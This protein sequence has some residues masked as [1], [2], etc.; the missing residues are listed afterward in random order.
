MRIDH[1][2]RLT[3]LDRNGSA[4]FLFWGLAPSPKPR[5]GL[6]ASPGPR[7]RAKPSWTLF[8]L[9]WPSATR[10]LS[11]RWKGFEFILA[12]LAVPPT[13]ERRFDTTPLAWR[14]V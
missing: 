4:A 14:A 6:Y 1:P 7:Q 10:R 8:P 13:P 3:R 5:A 12:R 2:N 11:T 9:R